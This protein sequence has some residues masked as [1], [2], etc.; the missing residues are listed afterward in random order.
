MS[1]EEIFNILSLFRLKDDENVI[2]VLK[3]DVEG[4]EFKILPQLLQGTLLNQ[5]R[6]IVAEIHSDDQTERKIED[7]K[8]MLRN[9]HILHRKEYRVLS[10]NPNFVMGRL[11]SSDQYY[12]NFDVSLHKNV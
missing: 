2:S 7:M 5:I 11:I 10:Y 6:Q 12:T 8:S 4:Y 9:L 3:L 1:I